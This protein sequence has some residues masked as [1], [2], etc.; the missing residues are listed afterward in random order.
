MSYSYTTTS[1][2]DNSAAQ[3]ACYTLTGLSIVLSAMAFWTVGFIPAVMMTAA[4]ASVSFLL[5]GAVIRF[6]QAL[7]KGHSVTAGLVVVMAL[8]CL[9]LEAGL[10]HYGLEHLNAQYAIAPAWAL[11]PLSF[12]LSIFNVFSQ[13]AFSRDLPTP[14]PRIV[15]PLHA[16]NTLGQPGELVSHDERMARWEAR[17]VQ[18][19]DRVRPVDPAT[20]KLMAKIGRRVRAGAAARAK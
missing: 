4:F 12:G 11:W 14:R 19:P 15:V 6:S 1:A 2:S 7:A 10:T 17:I 13:Y 5:A 8:V 3:V 18:D 16:D 20:A 9:C